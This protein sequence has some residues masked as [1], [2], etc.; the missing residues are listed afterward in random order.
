MVGGERG[1][2]KSTLIAACTCLIRQVLNATGCLSLYCMSKHVLEHQGL[3]LQEEGWH[4]HVLAA[5]SS[6]TLHGSSQQTVC[7]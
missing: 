2:F 3:L 5:G 7:C 4:M 1:S 6:F